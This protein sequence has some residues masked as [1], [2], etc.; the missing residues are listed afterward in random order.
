MQIVKAPDQRLESSGKKKR[1]GNVH[2][3]SEKLERK[4]HSA[5]WRAQQERKHHLHHVD[6]PALPKTGRPC[7]KAHGLTAR[8]GKGHKSRV[9]VLITGQCA[10][11]LEPYASRQIS[12]TE[13]FGKATTNMCRNCNMLV[14]GANGRAAV[15]A[16]VWRLAGGGTW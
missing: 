2:V 16:F 1:L 11:E 4:F 3:A 12:G 14:G 15:S 5:P 6:W 10:H 8:R 7:Q 13:N 9:N